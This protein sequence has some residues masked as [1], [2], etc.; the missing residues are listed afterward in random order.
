MINCFEDLMKVD[1]GK[2]FFLKFNSKTCNCKYK[3]VPM[4]KNPLDLFVYEKL[5]NDIKPTVVLEIGCFYGGSVLRFSDIFKLLNIP[6]RVIGVDVGVNE[7]PCADNIVWIIRDARSDAIIKKVC[8]S[9]TPID[10]V[11][12]IEDAS[13]EASDSLLFLNSYSDLVTVGSYYIVEDTCI[14]YVKDLVPE[15]QLM[16]PLSAVHK[17][18]KT[19]KGSNFV[20]DRSKETYIITNNPMGYLKRIK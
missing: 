2:D 6:G 3:D 10:V 7:K 14:D 4:L 8:G 18:I 15:W 11:M 5:I 20:I 13:H 17:F 12:I 1:W 19:E 9:I 16:G